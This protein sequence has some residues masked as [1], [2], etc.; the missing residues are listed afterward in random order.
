MYRGIGYP[1]PE[2]IGL[3]SEERGSDEPIDVD[4]VDAE[5]SSIQQATKRIKPRLFFFLYTYF[6]KNK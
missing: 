6:F 3:E 1:V 4:T 2:Y 5:E